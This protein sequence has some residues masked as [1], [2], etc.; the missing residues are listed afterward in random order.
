MTFQEKKNT[1]K[2]LKACAIN[3]DEK[4]NQMLSKH[5]IHYFPFSSS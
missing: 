1:V 5:Q 2:N 4:K 3:N